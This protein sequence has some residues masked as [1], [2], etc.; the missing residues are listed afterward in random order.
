MANAELNGRAEQSRRML[1]QILNGAGGQ[2]ETIQLNVGKRNNQNHNVD[3]SYYVAAG[4]KDH[5]SGAMKDFNRAIILYDVMPLAE[6]SPR[7]GPHADLYRQ[8]SMS[9]GKLRAAEHTNGA[10]LVAGMNFP[11]PLVVRKLALPP[12]TPM[13]QHHQQEQLLPRQGAKNQQTN[14]LTNFATPSPSRKNLR[15]TFR[16]TQTL[17]ES[18]VNKASLRDRLLQRELRRSLTVAELGSSRTARLGIR[19]NYSENSSRLISRDL[20]EEATLANQNK[21]GRPLSH[22]RKHTQIVYQHES[23]TQIQQDAAVPAGQDS[24]RSAWPLEQSSYLK[25]LGQ[26]ALDSNEKT[27]QWLL[28]NPVE[29]VVTEGAEKEGNKK[30]MFSEGQT[31]SKT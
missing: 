20:D 8:H 31:M 7:H 26:K 12:L 10:N 27:K 29:D 23:M 11:S 25:Q 19:N 22:Q 9:L 13:T 3:V 24:D 1:R 4:N 17:H 6:L 5:S 28:T 30:V 15:V 16:R 18:Q 2:S 21:G 14:E